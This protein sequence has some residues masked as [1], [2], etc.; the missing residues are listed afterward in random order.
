MVHLS[1][2]QVTGGTLDP[3]RCGTLRSSES[4]IGVP[5]VPRNDG[6]ES[7]N[8][9]AGKVRL[10]AFEFLQPEFSPLN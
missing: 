2:F 9:S 10:E 3:A 7:V 4:I 6:W 5:P 8:C 1:V